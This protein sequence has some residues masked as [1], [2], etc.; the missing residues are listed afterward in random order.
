L[1]ITFGTTQ[2]RELS[3]YSQVQFF[4]IAGLLYRLIPIQSLRE[5]KGNPKL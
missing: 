1:D 4:S 2:A 5:I 3:Q